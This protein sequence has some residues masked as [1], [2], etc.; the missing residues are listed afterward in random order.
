LALGPDELQEALNALKENYDEL[1]KQK[2]NQ[3]INLDK[4]AK[5]ICKEMN[6]NLKDE[7]LTYPEP[8]LKKY[9]DVCK[10]PTYEKLSNVEKDHL[11]MQSKTCVVTF[12]T[13]PLKAK[14]KKAY[15]NKWVSN[16]G[17][18]GM[19]RSFWFH[20]LEHEPEANGLWTYTQTRTHTDQDDEMC[21]DLEVGRTDTWD[22]RYEIKEMNCQFIVYGR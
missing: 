21:K 2:I 20:T 14:F 3:K 8:I 7:W 10:N 13:E 6:P 4:E 16:S 15:K 17:P 18:T 1:K 5:N 9:V 11:L 22:W 19:C 12:I